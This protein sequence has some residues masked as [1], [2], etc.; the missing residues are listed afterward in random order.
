MKSIIDK[1]MIY[2]LLLMYSINAFAQ[3]RLEGNPEA[4][5][6]FALSPDGETLA[7]SNFDGT[8]HLWDTATGAEKDVFRSEFK[9]GSGA[10]LTF[11][12]D[13]TL[14]ASGSEA[15]RVTLWDVATGK[16]K[17]VFEHVEA[18]TISSISFSPD[19][20]TLVSCAAGRFGTSS[21]F[22][23]FWDVET[24]EKKSEIEVPEFP[25]CSTFSPDGTTLAIGTTEFEDK[26]ISVYLWDIH[27]NVEIA[28]LEIAALQ[29]FRGV[30]YVKFSPDGTALAVGIGDSSLITLWD[31]V[32]RKETNRLHGYARGW[33]SYFFAFSPDGTILAGI[34]VDPDT[35][36]EDGLYFWDIFNEKRKIIS[37]PLRFAGVSPNGTFYAVEDRQEVIDGIHTYTYFI[38]T[39]SP[40]DVFM[41]V[42]AHGK[43]A[44]RW[45]NLKMSD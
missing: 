33:W 31:V 10:V 24:G 15:S 35:G 4:L 41:E 28:T 39:I 18:N 38:R 44:T 2:L 42:A 34:G 40:E 36:V 45:A 3:V 22:I 25:T 43:L 9:I 12:P 30:M 37:E 8:I 17:F 19:G 29:T 6:L 26:A 7:G 13:G 5:N 32:T 20:A 21:T 14:L 27:E 1:F 11:S 23:Y 16:A